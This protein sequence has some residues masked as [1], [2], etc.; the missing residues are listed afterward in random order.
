MRNSNHNVATTVSRI[1][2]IIAV[3]VAFAMPAGYCA[4]SSQYQ[5]GAMHTEAEMNAFLL[6]KVVNDSPDYWRFQ[7]HRL[8]ELLHENA[9]PKELPEYRYIRDLKGV[10]I[11]EGNAPPAPPLLSVSKPIYDAGHVVAHM[12]T[13]RSLRPL[14]LNT[15]IVALLGLVL[16]ASVFFTLRLLPLR[17]L[18][19][20]L[21]DLRSSDERFR[22][23][24]NASPE[25]IAI[26]RLPD[27]RIIDANESFIRITGRDRD[28]VIGHAL[29]DLELITQETEVA[30]LLQKGLAGQST[31]DIE[32]LLRSGSGVLCNVLISSESIQ[33]DDI[34]CMLITARDVTMLKHAEQRLDYLANFDTLTGLPNR[35]L[36]RDRL[37]QAMHRAVRNKHLVALMFLNLDRFKNVNDSLGQETGDR[38]LVEVAERLRDVLRDADTIVR[39]GAAD[40]DLEAATVSRLGGDEFTVVIEAMHHMDHAAVIAQKIINIF[41]KPFHL[42]GCDVYVTA[43]IG[44]SIYPLDDDGIDELIKHADTAMYH[45]KQVGRNNFQSYGEHLNARTRDR[46]LLETALRHAL[47][48]QEFILHYQ[49]KLDLKDNRVMGVEALLRWQ[50]PQRGLVPPLEFISL[51]EDNGLIL[52]VGEWVIRAA[53]EQAMRWRASGLPPLVMAVNLSPRQFRQDHLVQRI[54]HILQETG[55]EPCYLEFEIT[56]GLLMDNSE[57][58]LGILSELKAMGVSIAIDD[59]GTGYSSLS[60]LKRFPI[61][62]LKIDRAFVNDIT[63]DPDDAAIANAVIAL[64]KSMHLLIVAEGVE[65]QM[66]L[67]YLRAMGCHVAQGFLLSKPL[68][69]VALE[70]WWRQ[71][72]ETIRAN[73]N[74]EI[75][76]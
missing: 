69:A 50:H 12:V 38:L 68:V 33:L 67:D 66:Q 28:A 59:F 76:I 9:S 13:E 23:A 24:F 57:F 19:R 47:E 45:A 11:A 64:G 27:S 44:I 1:A 3:I 75:A 6:T 41:E 29:S 43:S 63:A 20:A 73:E 71:Q 61:D 56:E 40:A 60:Y 36:F 48:H 34:P 49:P 54:Q 18:N 31:R 22:K 74:T 37:T 52:P 5:L 16:G 46:L 7:G 53:C 39:G 51:L 21:A 65:T 17:A 14:L 42:Q 30:L 58:N 15:A 72:I 2:A 55:I 62:V 10:I 26:V 25:L 4:L 70:I 35:A 32:C 8:V